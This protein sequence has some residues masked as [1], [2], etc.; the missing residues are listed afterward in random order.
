MPQKIINVTCL[1]TACEI[2]LTTGTIDFLYLSFSH[3]SGFYYFIVSPSYYIRSIYMF[4]VQFI[5]ELVSPER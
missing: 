5:T 1:L 4:E 2:Y 3:L